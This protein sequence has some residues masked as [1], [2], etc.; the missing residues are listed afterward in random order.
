MELFLHSLMSF[1]NMKI[2]LNFWLSAII[3]YSKDAD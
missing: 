2:L 1:I 3:S